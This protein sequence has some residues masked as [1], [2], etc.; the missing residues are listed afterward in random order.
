MNYFTPTAVALI[1]AFCCPLGLFGQLTG[2]T[3]RVNF[4]DA[5]TPAPAPYLRDH[6]LPFQAQNGRTYGWV[7]PGTSTPLSLDGNGR[8]R[9]PDP[10]QDVLIET[11]MHMQYGDAG[12]DRGPTAPGAWEVEVP[13][14]TYRVTVM[15]GDLFPEGR[16]GTNHVINAEGYNLIYQPTVYGEVNQFTGSAVV[17]VNDGRLTLDANGGYNTKI[18]HVT[19]AA[20]APEPVAFFADVV[21]ANGAVD[22]SPHSFQMTVS[23]NTPPNYELDKASIVGRIRLFEQTD[24]GLF[25]VPSNTNDTGGGDAVTLT[26]RDGLKPATTYV[27]NIEGVQANRIGHLDDRITFRTFTSQFTTAAENDTNRPADLEGVSFTQIS[28]SNLGA[29]TADRFTTLTIGPDG[30]LYASTL[31][32]TI[33]RWT[34]RPDGTLSNLEELTIDLTGSD[35]PLNPSVHNSDVR[36]IIGLAFAPESTANNLVAYVTHSAVT[37]TDGPEWDGK[38]TRL[39]G[40]NLQTVQDVLIHLPRSKKDHLTNSIVF[41]PGGDLF[42]LQGSNTAGGEPDPSWGMRK[43]SLLAAAVLRLNLGKLPTQLPLSVYTTENITAINHAPTNSITMSDGTYNPYAQ[44]SPLTLYATGIRNAYDM[45]FH[46]NGW[47]YVPTN[48]TAG[49]NSTSPITPSSI[50]YLSQD[51]SGIGV[52]RANGTFFTDPSIPSMVGGETQKDWLFKTKGGSY[53]G[54]PNPYRGEFV[55]N[56]G[57]LAYSGLPGQLETSYRDVAKYPEDLGPD[58]NYREVA[59]DFG[60]NKSPN[61]VVEYKSDAFN[62]KLKGMLLVARFSGQD[63]ILVLQPGNNSGDIIHAFPDVPGLQSLDDPLELVE[64]VNSGNLYVAQYDRDGGGKQKILLLRVS[65]A[66]QP[67]PRIV[68][69]PLEVV[70]QAT[71]NSPNATTDSKTIKITNEGTADLHIS[72]KYFT[73]PYASQFR[74]TGPSQLT[75]APAAAQT[76]TI[77]YR[78]VL[79]YNALGYQHAELVFE[80]DGNQG[81]PYRVN[82]FALKSAGYGGNNEPPLQTIVRTLGYD[83]N[84]GWTSLANTTEATLLGDEVA[85]DYFTAAGPGPVTMTPVAR[86]SPAEALPFGYYTRVGATPSHQTVGTAAAGQENAQ[87]LYPPLVT[88]STSFTAPEGGFGLFIQS[89]YF[90]R[91]SYTQDGLNTDVPHRVRVYPLRDRASRPLEDSYLVCFEDAN[92]GDYQDY[93]FVVSNVRPYTAAAEQTVAFNTQINFQ[94]GSFTPPSGYVADTGKPFG[95]RSG[96]MTYGWIDAYSRQPLNREALAFGATRGVSN[97]TSEQ[98]KL[99]RSGNALDPLGGRQA[100]WEIAVPNGLYRVELGVGDPNDLNSSHTL[101]AEGVTIIDNFNPASRFYESKSGV[102]EV[103][104]GKLTI[105]DGG[106]FGKSNTKIT[107]IKVSNVERPTPSGA[108]VRIENMLKVPGTN[109]GFPYE[110]FFTFHRN[111]ELVTSKGYPIKVRDNSVMRIHNEGVSPLVITE[112]TTTDTRDFVIEGVT[113][114]AGGLI[115]E[116]GAYVDATVRFV[117]SGGQNGRLVTETLKMS[118]NADNG[119]LTLATF[120][121][122]YMALIGGNAEID[123][124]QVM[125]AFDFNTRMG[126]DAQGNIIVRPSS[127]YPQAEQV[128]SGKEGDMILSQFFVQADPSK[129]LRMLSLS[130]LHGEG[131]SPTE[132][133]DQSY[134]VVD[135]FRFNHDG[136]Y[137]QT[138]L[139]PTDVAG[140]NAVAGKSI[141]N[142]SVPF[143]IMVGGYSTYGGS[144][145]NLQAPVLGVRVYRAID[146]NGRVIPNEYIINQ[147]FVENGCGVG[148]A[149]C[150]WN[151]NTSYIINARPLGVPSATKVPDVTVAVQQGTDYKVTGYFSLG[152]PGNVLQYTARTATGGTL[153]SWIVLDERTGTFRITAPAGSSGTTVSVQVTGTDYNGLTASSTFRV[154]VSGTPVANEAPIAVASASPTSGTAP[155]SVQLDGTASQDFDGSIATYA[156]AW[157]G[158]TATGSTPSVVFSQGSYAVTLTV[159]DNRG[160]TDSDVISIR[161]TEPAPVDPP[162]TGG[163]DLPTTAWLEAECAAVGASWS[164]ISDPAA[165]NGKYAVVQSGNSYDVSPGDNAANR[166]RFTA[167]VAGGSYR[168]FARVSALGGG[169]DSFWVR[170]NAGAW[171]KWSSG[172]TQGGV[173]NWNQLPVVL[174]L[175]QGANTI[176]I[177]YRE[178]G[179]KLDKLHLTQ[180]TT[181]PSGVGAADAGCTTGGSDPEPPVAGTKTSFSLEAECAVVGSQWTTLTDAN[182]SNGRYAVVLNGNSTDVAPADVAANR[183]RFTL[184]DAKAGLYHLYARVNAANGGDDSFWVRI[185]NGGWYQWN[186]SIRQGVGFAWNEITGDR[187]VLT[188]GTN[189]ID[190]AFREDGTKLDKVYLSQVAGIPTGTGSASENCGGDTPPAE[191]PVADASATFWLEAECGLVGGT[192]KTETDPAATNGSY[193]VVRTASSTSTAPADLPAN[194]VRFTLENAVNGNYTLFARIGAASNLDDSYWVRVNNGDW[195]KWSSGI[196]HDGTFQW[197]KLPVGLTLTA[198]SNTI[199]F[200]Y[201]EAGAKLD[202]LH[203]NRTGASPVGNGESGTNCGGTTTPPAS[204]DLALEAECALTGSGWA[205]QSSTA[206]SGGTYLVFNGASRTAVP[207]T[208]E[209]SQEVKFSVNVTTAGLYHLFTRIDAPDVTR[210][211]LWVRIDNGAWIKFWQELGGAQLLTTGFEWRELTNDGKAT[212]FNLTAG[213]HTVTVANREAGTRLDKLLLKPSTTLPTGFGTTASNC[214]TTTSR[215]MSQFAFAKREAPRRVETELEVFPNP[216]QLRTTLELRSDHLGQVR[217]LLTDMTGRT[218][219]EQTYDKSFTEL[220]TDIEVAS[221]PAGVYRLRVIEGDRQTVRSFVKM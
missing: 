29:G 32:E 118:S 94:D 198:G 76:Y 206:A 65:D 165:A 43:E 47:T 179:A 199:D 66:T 141:A 53:H 181:P 187:P 172:I 95:T 136:Y 1:L 26:T 135:N 45:V 124:Q 196:R 82:M 188:Q 50:A 218:V 100:D 217:V 221:L 81:A 56:H 191:P 130:A 216:A 128:N 48:G 112:L 6:G 166:I 78:P 122:G 127:D 214:G 23:V 210:N 185:N 33:K 156:W 62:G 69:T 110:D 93:V 167:T 131:G 40:P 139:P 211:S 113:I 79:D 177:A 88:G 150:D 31:G 85:A 125:N 67:T 59:Y 152:Y 20:A 25:E 83:I 147:D 41:G 16:P 9:R 60:M 38:L 63:D 73:G 149:N 12:G 134:R 61:G 2:D 116:P 107:Y 13:N 157:P 158:G 30:K 92:N 91:K 49:N 200:A 178:D 111:D 77:E 155:L 215:E 84:V 17:Q 203:L 137:F 212:S 140:S 21:P 176:D 7:T 98:D 115:V 168:L 34:I 54:H 207:T 89:N 143:Q 36:F 161:A 183:I 153:P 142:I 4:S 28:G 80:S 74:V 195:Y 27:F 96:G 119:M 129:P 154:I 184:T 11:L 209:P 171:Y 68:S 160:A 102:V 39:S 46:T 186:G 117:T 148:T 202:K 86:Y 170:V 14:G 104:D 71:V 75:L 164:V 204:T 169:D 58:V 10:D 15:A 19:I 3:V 35:H 208:D 123:A 5:A 175:T 24:A 213:V 159:T 146:R 126:R 57:G 145:T 197:N 70:L 51:T 90:G 121:G 101:R 120:R 106:A 37:L 151:D 8:N 201:R 72:G 182:A 55:L 144:K 22:V 192:W 97:V 173:F 109:R 108:V 99:R 133:R 189:T 44:N 190:F 132:L 193:V 18:C 163:G 42:F 52:R 105:D 64:D 219:S 220:R 194:R 174:N 205:R 180:S 103:K 87:R 138:L 114:P 162:P